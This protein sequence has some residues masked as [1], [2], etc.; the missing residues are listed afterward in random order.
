MIAKS[1]WMLSALGWMLMI[2]ALV[3][4]GQ[5]CSREAASARECGIHCEPHPFWIGPSGRCYCGRPPEE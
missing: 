1:F 4:F 2:G 5:K 3:L